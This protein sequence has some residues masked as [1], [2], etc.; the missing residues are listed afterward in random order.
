M[1]HAQL[2]W[3]PDGGGCL[4]VWD[5]DK[6]VYGEPYDWAC[7]VE[8]HSPTVVTLHGVT[9]PLTVSRDRAIRRCLLA[10]GVRLVHYERRLHGRIRHVTRHLR[11]P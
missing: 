4:R 7:A 2:Q 6:A 1:A 5:R 11:L 9:T 3:F 8:R 10:G